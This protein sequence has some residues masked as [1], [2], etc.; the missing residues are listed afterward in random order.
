MNHTRSLL[1]QGPARFGLWLVVL[2]AAL[3][4]VVPPEAFAQADVAERGAGDEKAEPTAAGKA[5][6]D[7]LVKHYLTMYGKHLKS[8]DWVVRAMGV[9]GL[10]EIDDPRISAR[11]IEV[12]QKD[13]DPLVRAYAWAAVLARHKSL[14]DEQRATWTRTGKQMLRDE[15]LNG[16]L[17]VGLIRVMADEG[18]TAENVKLFGHFFDNTNAM[19]PSDIP[20][21]LALQRCLATWKH[22]KLTR[23]LISAMSNINTAW[24]AELVLQGLSDKV[25]TAHSLMAQDSKAIWKT[26]QA[27]WAKWYKKT[28]L[29]TL[30]PPVLTD[31]DRSP[32]LIRPP[33][34][35]A[36]PA[37]PRWRKDLEL[38]PLQMQDMDVVFAVDATGSMGP[39]ISWIQRDVIKM[40]KAFGQ[41]CR[42][43]RIGVLFY[44]DRGDGNVA[45]AVPLTNN[46]EALVR[47]VAGVKAKGGGDE[48]EAVYEA[49][50]DILKNMKWASDNRFIITVADAPPHPESM[51]Q[52]KRTITKA[53]EKG[54]RFHFIKARTM[55]S[56][57]KVEVFDELA[58][59]GNGSSV[60]VTFVGDPDADFVAIDEMSSSALRRYFK[61]AMRK[62][63]A[64][65]ATGDA[66]EAGDLQVVVNVLKSVLSDDYQDRVEPLARVLLAFVHSPTPEKR[67]HFGLPPLGATDAG[68][69]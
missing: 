14:T 64:R 46:G 34:R 54:F 36:D 19:D 25:P 16:S 49:L 48:P 56:S 59:L 50:R 22:Q 13:Q 33:Q 12:M 1:H 55:F 2:A 8:T 44:R 45:R 43:P 27:T 58:T 39:V 23:K 31:H 4:A 24:R 38:K 41:I 57:N 61:Q 51:T 17:R 65:V 20:T 37:D 21:L 28:D 15:H 69:P 63:Q 3:V 10:S 67:E 66:R 6:I 68:F 47:A 62:Y 32:A 5:A 35:I 40:M 18:P 30:E 53:A 9:I 60:W 11:L 29:A 42:K 7:A 52:L 26:V